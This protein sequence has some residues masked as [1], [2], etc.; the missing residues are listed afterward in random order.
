MKPF[1]IIDRCLFSINEI[2]KLENKENFCVVQY[3]EII[4][5]PQVLMKKI[6]KFLEMPEYEHDFNNIIKLEKDNDEEIGQPKNMH[7]IR[8]KLE[9]NSREPKN[10]LSDYV[11]NKY[12]N[13]GWDKI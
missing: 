12:S 3:D 9:K 8:K 5:N 1:G 4:N 13:M 7:K 6:Y 10:V 11:I 2:M